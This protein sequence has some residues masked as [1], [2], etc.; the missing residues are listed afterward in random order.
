MQFGAGLG[1]GRMG[2]GGH[3]PGTVGSVVGT[4]RSHWFA[5]RFRPSYQLD[6]DSTTAR[7]ASSAGDC[8]RER[9]A[10]A[11][12]A[13]E[14]IDDGRQSSLGRHAAQQMRD[15]QLPDA[16]ARAAAVDHQMP[17]GKLGERRGEGGGAVHDG[18][19]NETRAGL[20]ASAGRLEYVGRLCGAAAGV[21]INAGH[22]GRR[23][24]VA[25]L[26]LPSKQSAPP[27]GRLLPLRQWRDAGAVGVSGW[28]A[29]RATMRQG[30]RGWGRRRSP[31]AA[32]APGLNRVMGLST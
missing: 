8:R 32:Q 5:G 9:P 4:N 13:A 2:N 25:A 11:V 14:A 26:V 18:N 23:G 1:A 10:T 21:G 20:Q 17:G 31:A 27:S 30:A 6:L 29:D 12:L 28:F 22:T 16:P 15:V 3:V 19:I 7:A 24:T